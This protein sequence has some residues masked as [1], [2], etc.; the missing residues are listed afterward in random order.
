M[1]QKITSNNNNNKRNIA[2]AHHHSM[3]NCINK[4]LK[5]LEIVIKKN[6]NSGEYSCLYLWKCSE[7][8]IYVWIIMMIINEEKSSTSVRVCVMQV[9]FRVMAKIIINMCL[10]IADRAQSD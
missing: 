3:S 7:I 6:M 2:D 10:C 1:K 9:V 5:A 8:Q 4:N